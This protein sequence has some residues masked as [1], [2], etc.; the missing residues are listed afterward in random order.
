MADRD[1]AKEF[2]DS[3]LNNENEKALGIISEWEQNDYDDANFGLALVILCCSNDE[4]EF[5]DIFEV[6]MN[7]MKDKPT[8]PSLFDWFNSAAISLM[9]KRVDEDMGLSQMFNNPYKSNNHS[10]N[11]AKEFLDLFE[12]ILENDNPENL[13]ELKDIVNKWTDDYP[14]DA[15][16]YCAYVILNFKNRTDEELNDNVKKAKDYSPKDKNSYAR[17]LT[18]MNAILEKIM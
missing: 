2:R 14:D 12:D 16:M 18:I 8:N 3:V 17:L 1:Y 9:E 7:A 4:I 11:Y 6:Y 15:N 13:N 5:S 10:N